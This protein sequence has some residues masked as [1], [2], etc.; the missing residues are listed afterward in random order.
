M[1]K[2]T[3][4]LRLFTNLSKQNGVCNAVK[5]NFYSKDAKVVPSPI[6]ELRIYQILA[7]DFKSTT[8]LFK[9]YISLRTKHSK[10]L[11][12]WNGEIGGSITQLVHLWEYESLSHRRKVR[13]GMMEDKEWTT[14]FLPKLLPTIDDWTNA[15]VAPLPKSKLNL[16][17]PSEPGAV[18]QL[19]TIKGSAT[20]PHSGAHKGEILVGRFVG[21][22]GQTNTEYRLWRYADIDDLFAASWKRALDEPQDGNSLLLYPISFS[23]LQ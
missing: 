8:E 20:K 2:S 11:G 14:V 1:L 19:E 17:L 5:C 21:V 16:D 3:S 6:Y 22:L 18:Y 13:T 9:Q 10:L 23:P 7:K 4:T 15:L 12:F